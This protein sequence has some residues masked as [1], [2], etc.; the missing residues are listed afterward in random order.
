MVPSYLMWIFWTERNWHSFE[1][2]E[3]SLVQLQ[4][5]CQKTLFDWSRGWGSSNCFSFLE[6]LSSH[7][8]APL[9]F[10]LCCCLLLFLVYTIMNT[11][12]LLS[13]FIHLD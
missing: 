8:I 5:L 3:K 1:A 4:V 9:S 11:L 12:Y 6:F 2:T 10:F 7:R 13:S